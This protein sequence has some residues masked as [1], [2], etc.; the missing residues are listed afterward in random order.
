MRRLTFGIDFDGTIVEH[1]FPEIGKE[2][3]L[4]I[5][6]LKF[7]KQRGHDIILFTC[8]EDCERKYLKEAIEWLRVRGVVPDSVNE[9]TP[10]YQSQ[11]YTSRKPFWDFLID[12]SAGFRPENWNWVRGLVIS[13]EGNDQNL[14]KYDGNG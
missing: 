8:R 5:D 7:I 13:M 3:P 10:Y 2:Y 14:A 12:D 1:V 9:N 4:A 11:G 6:A